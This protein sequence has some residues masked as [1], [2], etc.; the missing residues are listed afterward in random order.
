MTTISVSLFIT[1]TVTPPD[2]M[3]PPVDGLPV[4]PDALNAQIS[5][6]GALRERFSAL[7]PAALG[8]AA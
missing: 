1:M 4:T 8:T 6:I 2:R 3:A 5:D 7:T